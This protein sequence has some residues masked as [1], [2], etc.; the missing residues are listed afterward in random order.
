[1]VSQR[2]DAGTEGSREALLEALQQGPV[3]MNYTGHGSLTRLCDEGLLKLEDGESWGNPALV[4]AWTCLAAHYVHPTQDSMAEVW[5]R[6]PRG[7]AVAFLGAVG[8]TTSREQAPFLRAFYRDLVEQ[9]RLGDA[10]L[11]A[12][13]A[14]WSADVRWGYVLLGDPALRFSLE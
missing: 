5:L 12:L 7:G 4:V 8:E 13:R 6:V 11:A 9:E 3:W 2:I 14:G 10:W 1:V